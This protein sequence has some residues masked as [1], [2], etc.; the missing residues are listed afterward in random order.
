MSKSVIDVF[1]AGASTGLSELFVWI[2]KQLRRKRTNYL[3]N[4]IGLLRS[5]TEKEMEENIL[6]RKIFCLKVTKNR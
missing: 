5:K 1:K 3:E 6:K 4:N 2:R